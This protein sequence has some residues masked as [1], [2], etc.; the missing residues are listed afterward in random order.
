MKEN[1]ILFFLL[2]FILSSCQKNK[3]KESSPS[4]MI[5][6]DKFNKRNFLIYGTPT[7]YKYVNDSIINT[8]LINLASKSDRSF[9]DFD[10][11]RIKWTDSTLIISRFF[12]NSM[13]YDFQTNFY[14]TDTSLVFNT[15]EVGLIDTMDYISHKEIMHIDIAITHPAELKTTLRINKDDLDK[16]IYYNNEKIK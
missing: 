12:L 11:L 14:S 4:I 10:S 15:L 2:L 5:E 8:T 3:N 7:Y 6:L 1:L 9:T 16:A 13:I